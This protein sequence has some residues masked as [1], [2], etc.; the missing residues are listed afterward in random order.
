VRTTERSDVFMGDELGLWVD[1]VTDEFGLVFNFFYSTAQV[2][3]S[4]A[5][6]EFDWVTAVEVT[7][8]IIEVNHAIGDL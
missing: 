2:L 4:L 7:H 8:T 6:F 1:K 3:K 5:D